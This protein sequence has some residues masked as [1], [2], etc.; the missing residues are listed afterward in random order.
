MRKSTNDF[1]CGLCFLAIG[2][3]FAA[4]TGGLEGKSLIFPRALIAVV[5]L[6]G[7]WFT[8][9]G[10]WLRRLEKNPHPHGEAVAWSKV[11]IIAPASVLYALGIAWLGFFS[12][13][14]A[15]HDPVR[16]ASGRARPGLE[17]PAAG[18]RGLQ[19]GLFRAG[20]AL[21][22]EAAQRAHAS[23]PAVLS[24]LPFVPLPTPAGGGTLSAPRKDR[25]CSPRTVAPFFFGAVLD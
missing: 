21:F 1:L 20:L 18:E 12:S 17:T 9:K 24:G 2:I 11:G 3:A 10:L 8:G 23:G 15:V 16:T 7:L 14:A 5:L 13:T 6:G 25:P 19:R 4:Q 22:R